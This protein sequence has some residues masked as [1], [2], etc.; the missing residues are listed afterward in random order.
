[1]FIAC[2]VDSLLGLLYAG[3]SFEG[4]T[5]DEGKPCGD[6]TKGPPSMVGACCDI[7]LVIGDE[8][9]V[10][11]RPLHVG[12]GKTRAD[13]NPLRGGECHHSLGEGGFKFFVN[14]GAESDGK[15][16]YMAFDNTS[17]GISLFFCLYEGCHHLLARQSI[18][19]GDRVRLQRLTV[20]LIDCDITDSVDIGDKSD[21]VI[22][23]DLFRHGTNSYAADSLSGGGASATTIIEESIFF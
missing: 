8:G 20:D 15:M 11:R 12:A 14:G 4:G 21:V 23:E 5:E 16:V 22:G 2:G 9:I 19:A 10:V 17:E 18:G 3:G 6:A 13:L 7:S 1:M